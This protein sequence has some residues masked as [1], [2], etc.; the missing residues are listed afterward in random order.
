MLLTVDRIEGDLA[1][2]EVAGQMVDFP[3]A[4]LPAGAAEGSTWNLTLTPVSS[5]DA[6]AR[7]RLERL[8][9]NGPTT[10]SIDL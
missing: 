8:A 2:V 5:S 9:Q 1:V 10:D 7:A 3:L 6:E 4:A